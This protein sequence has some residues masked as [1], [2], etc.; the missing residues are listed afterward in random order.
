M[1]NNP[2]HRRSENI[3]LRL[4]NDII[5]QL[6]SDAQQKQISLNTLANQVFDS[7][8]NFINSAKT[9]MLALPKAAIVELLEGYSDEGIKAIVERVHEKSALDIA[10]QLRGRYDFKALLDILG[11]ML[12]ASG[13]AYK[14]TTD[15]H[16]KNRHTFIIQFGMGRKFSLFIAEYLKAS[17]EPVSAKKVEYTITDNMVAIAVEGNT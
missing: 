6:K 16:N 11:Y 13:F 5:A 12:K 3:S 4:N 2:S 1:E 8:V 10:F 7:Y 14:H 9:D 15:E 17:F